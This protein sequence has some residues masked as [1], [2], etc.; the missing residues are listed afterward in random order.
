MNAQTST[1]ELLRQVRDYIRAPYAFP[2]GYP[3]ILVMKDGDVVCA[4]CAGIEYRQISEATRDSIRDPGF[5]DGWAAAGVDLHLEGPELYCCHCSAAIESAYGDPEQEVESD[6][7]G[8]EVC[9]PRVMVNPLNASVGSTLQA[10]EVRVLVNIGLLPE[11]APV[12]PEEV[13]DRVNA[14]LLE[15]ARTNFLL[16]DGYEVQS[17]TTEMDVRELREVDE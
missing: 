13:Q 5:N 2:G 15:A 7:E 14:A 6:P 11:Q 8:E 4:K 16:P 3:K 10:I 12:H 9:P 1:A 17:V